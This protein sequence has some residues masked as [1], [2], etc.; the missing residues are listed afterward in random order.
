[1]LNASLVLLLLCV[2]FAAVLFP[3]AKA[4]AVAAFV[5][6]CLP[7]V[8]GWTLLLQTRGAVALTAVTAGAA[9][10]DLLNSGVQ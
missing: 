1:M 4:A 5:D 2:C 9:D 7:V 3:P 10:C 8:L 6:T